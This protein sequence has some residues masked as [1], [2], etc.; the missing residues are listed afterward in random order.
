MT[1]ATTQA[2]AIQDQIL[3]LVRQGQDAT[4]KAVKAWS[5][6]IAK[7]APALPALPAV[8]YVENLPKP[9]EVVDLGFDFAERLLETQRK[10]AKEV[11]T[12]AQPV[13][14]T[15]AKASKN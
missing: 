2:T 12:A 1:T 5:E 8:P 15:A 10:F 4:V 11:L 3:D 6:N 9:A 14:D 13:L 7:V